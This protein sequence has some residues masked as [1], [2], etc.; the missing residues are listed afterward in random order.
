M[1][2]PSLRPHY[3]MGSL[4]ALLL[5][6]TAGA[7]LMMNGLYRPFLSE[8]IVAFQWF[9]D[10]V[11]LLFAPVLVVAM[12]LTRRGSTRAFTLWTGVLLFAGYYYAF[13]V[14]DF[15]YTVYYPLYLAVIGLALWSLLGLLTG[16]DLQAFARQVDER[17]PV[18][19]IALVLAMT[20]LFVPIWL[21]VIVQG[22][23]TQQPG[24]TDL[25]FVLDLPFLIPACVYAAV[26]VWRQRPIGYLLSGPLLFKSGVSGILLT[27]GE[28][29][30]MQRGLPPALDQ[31]AMYL[32]LAV[33]GLAALTV[34]LR[35][36]DSVRDI[37]NR[38]VTMQPLPQQGR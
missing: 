21:S 19:F 37:A 11:S 8:S 33:A 17:M 13:Y 14:F 15:V 10:L 7:G 29:L 4:T 30:K 28:V 6:I 16:A 2:H 36:L 23:R 18:R 12:M 1:I 25:V 3:W 24:N 5:V 35:H 38:T 26:Q 31:L 27:G 9:Q 22:I 32:F 34:Y 20:V